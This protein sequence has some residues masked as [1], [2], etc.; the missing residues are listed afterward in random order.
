M[1]KVV[2]Y[3]F[4]FV[5]GLG[6][7]ALYYVYDSLTSVNVHASD[8][9]AAQEVYV[10]PATSV[11]QLI[12]QLGDQRAI[13]SERKIN[14]ACRLMSWQDPTE[15]KAG[16]YSLP[17][18][19]SSRE[20]INMFRAG[21]QSPILLTINQHRTLDEL[22]GS[23][24]GQLL[25][26]SLALRDY[27][28]GSWLPSQEVLDTY[29]ALS[30]FLP[31]TYEMYWTASAE[32]VMKRMEQEHSR[33]WTAQRK[34]Q[35]NEKGLSLAEVYTLASIVEKE[36]NHIPERPRV[37]GL[38]LNR[39]NQ[40]IPLQA[41][42]TV[43]FANQDFSIRRVLTKHLQKDSPYNTYVHVGL[44]PGPICVPSTSSILAVLDAEAHGYLF[45]CAK[46]DQAG[47]HN[48]A[49]TLTQHNQNAKIY[50][51]WLNQQGIK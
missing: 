51:Q 12:D 43:V 3:L 26:D 30:I 29:N 42:P 50:H 31:N 1:K 37:A 17:L 15:V 33:F 35:A 18:D 11:S 41:D 24:G 38:Y 9:T 34:N 23:I 4:L 48:F 40:G 5:L 44:P 36:T 46:P 28:T 14:L 16:H 10:Y 19:A 22:C 13:L 27:I 47:Q 32:D 20:I 8:T 7:A 49:R 6:G 25:L 21:N 45:M 39:L 2:L